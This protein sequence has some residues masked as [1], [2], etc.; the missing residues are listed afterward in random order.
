MY[1][2]PAQ[3]LVD[4]NYSVLYLSA[5]CAGSTPDG[6][7]WASSTL[8]LRLCREALPTGFWIAGD[9]AYRCRNG[10]VTPWTA[11]KLLDDEFGVSRDTFNFY[12]SS[13]RMHVEQAFEMLVLRFGILWRKLMFSL[14]ANVLVLAA[15][16][17]LHHFCI[18][19]GEA[20]K[21]AVLGPEER[22]VSDAAFQR[23][24]RVHSKLDEDSYPVLSKAVVATWKAAVLGT[25]SI[26]DCM[27]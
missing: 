16:F 4:A 18:E 1:A 22:S 12:N 6:I 20:A 17:H 3:A 14:Q 10:I 26:E 7:S 13:L 21:G 24:F 25:I 27:R 8:G 19:H 2:I 15:H 9:A 11:G 23:W 5:K